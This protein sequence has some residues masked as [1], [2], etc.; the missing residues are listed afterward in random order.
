MS[1]KWIEH[2]MR[3]THPT[4]GS[5]DLSK[6]AHELLADLREAEAENERLRKA[7]ELYREADEAWGIKETGC[8]ARALEHKPRG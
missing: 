7:L 5:F 3:I 6:G 1:D 8:A 2:G 4:K